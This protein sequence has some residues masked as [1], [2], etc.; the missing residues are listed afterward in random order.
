M[1]IERRVELWF[2]GDGS[3][4]GVPSSL[5][6]V[7]RDG[8]S[9]WAARDEEPRSRPDR[10]IVIRV[11]IADRDDDAVPVRST[12]A[13]GPRRTAALL[14]GGAG[15]LAG[16]LSTDEHP[17]PFPAIPSRDLGLD[18]E[19]IV[20][21]DHG[22]LVE[23]RRPVLR[24]WAVVIT[25]GIDVGCS[26]PDGAPL[27]PITVLTASDRVELHPTGAVHGNGSVH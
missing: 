16:V 23:M 14:D 8:P 1:V 6:A 10:H 9:L 27:R 22:V 4:A 26:M 5:S 11:P 24:G 21:V 7:Y 20:G 17:T 19:G 13:G 15:G 25:T 18:V 3:S 2:G 12:R